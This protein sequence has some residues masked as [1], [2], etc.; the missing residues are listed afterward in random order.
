MPPSG[1]ISPRTTADN[2][3]STANWPR[4]NADNRNDNVN[5]EYAAD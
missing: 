1:A 2:T 5:G 4:T 3:R